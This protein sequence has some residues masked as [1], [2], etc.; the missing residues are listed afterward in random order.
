MKKSWIKSGAIAL[1]LM[2]VLTFIGCDGGTTTRWRYRETLRTPTRD[3]I[4]VTRASGF[5]PAE[6]MEIETTL[7]NNGITRIRILRTGPHETASFIAPVRA[8]LIPRIIDQQTLG[9]DVMA[10]A[11][12]TSRGVINAV[13]DAIDY[14]GGNSV[15]WFDPPPRIG[16]TVRLPADGGMF[17]VI[18]VGLGGTGVAAYARASEIPGTRIFGIEWGGMIGGNSLLAEFPTDPLPEQVPV[19]LEYWEEQ[20]GFIPEYYSPPTGDHGQHQRGGMKPDIVNALMSNVIDIHNWM[21]AAP[22]NASLPTGFRGAPFDARLVEMFQAAGVPTGTWLF[23][24]GKAALFDRMMTASVARNPGNDFMVQLRG[25]ELIIVDDE[26]I[27]V[28]ARHIPTN[29]IYRIYGHTVILATGGFIGNDAMMREFFGHSMRLE[30]VATQA[31]YGIRMGLQAGG[32]TYNITMPPMVHISHVLNVIQDP[33]I[34]PTTGVNLT[35]L[36]SGDFI[37]GGTP[38]IQDQS[39]DRR[40]KATLSSMLLW[41]NNLIVGLHDSPWQPYIPLRGG[42]PVGAGTRFANEQLSGLVMGTVSYDN[43]KVNGYFAAIF[44]DDMFPQ[45]AAATAPAWGIAGGLRG[46]GAAIPIDQVDLQLI[47]YLLTIGE[48]TGNVIRSLTFEQLANRLQV[49]A[50]TLRETI[51]RY[52]EAVSSGV[53]VEFGKAATHLTLAIADPD[54]P[55][56]RFTAILGAGYYY[57]TCGGLDIDVTMRVLRPN[58]TPIPNLFAGGQDAMGV[59]HNYRR[60]YSLIGGVAQAWVSFSGHRAGENAAAEAERR[61]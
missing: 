60:E 25:E 30:A 38:A 4:F 52:N 19:I 5:C 41:G 37:T 23:G 28:L 26:I 51:I 21:R 34:H 57:G 61:R 9:V 35:T 56:A 12:L 29:T 15:E 7:S 11:T 10:G 14:A 3:G 13:A 8:T 53:D 46:Q 16:G 31:G 45:I 27:G 39:M 20:W 44:S 58:R 59:L 18:I 24:S 42:R 48:R 43:W 36:R 32:A 33:I 55:N 6:Q 22:Y 50:A 40:W 49:P 2:I 1:A 17:D 54:D 47:N